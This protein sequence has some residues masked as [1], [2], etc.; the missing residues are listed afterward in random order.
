MGHKE[1]NQTNQFF[2]NLVITCI[3]LYVTGAAE[4]GKSTLVK[5]MKIIHNE[6]FTVDELIAF[7]VH[8]YFMGVS[9]RK[10]VFGVWEQQRRTFVIR[11][12]EINEILIF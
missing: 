8:N 12:L 2:V 5:Q 6:G 4:S 7:K 9:A 11:F 1:S 10:P 3:V